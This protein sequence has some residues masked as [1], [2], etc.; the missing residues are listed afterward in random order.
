[1]KGVILSALPEATLVDVTHDSVRRT[2]RPRAWCSRATGGASRP[3]R[4]TSW[5]SIR[6]RVVAGGAGGGC[7]RPVPR[8]SRQRGAVAGADHARCTGRGAVDPSG[9][10]VDVPRPRRL[11]A[12]RGG[13]GGR[14]AP[15]PGRGRRFPARSCAA[16]RSPPGRA[17]ARF[18]GKSSPSIA[19]ATPSRTCPGPLPGY[20]A[21]VGAM[22]LPCTTPTPMSRRA[23]RWRSRVERSDRD[24]R[25]GGQCGPAPRL[26]RGA[27][28]VLR[29]A[30]RSTPIGN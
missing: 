10:L 2:S 1:M 26:T 15:R 16:R 8:G 4:S 24:R 9:C 20:G 17:T 23:S 21:W 18:A 27:A 3:A 12:G 25:A 22:H 29:P 28:I 7:R 13:A 6:R 14:D 11:L 5:W 19:S 30:P